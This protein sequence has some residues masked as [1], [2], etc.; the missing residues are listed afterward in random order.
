LFQ[1]WLV[2]EQ[3]GQP[4]QPLTQE[5]RKW[6]EGKKRTTNG[7][8]RPCKA[9]L[10]GCVLSDS[11]ALVCAGWT[12]LLGC[13]RSRAAERGSLTARLPSAHR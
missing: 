4:A 6:P 3:V 13:R 12:S 10:P 7:G 5:A 2:F 8:K 9:R 11:S 1:G